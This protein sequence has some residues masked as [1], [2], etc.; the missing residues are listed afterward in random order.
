MVYNMQTPH[1][2][3]ASL[4]NIEKIH[5]QNKRHTTYAGL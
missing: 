1:R 3:T 5:V 4:T 2:C